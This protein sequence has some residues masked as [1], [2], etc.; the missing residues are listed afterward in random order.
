MSRPAWD[1][2]FMKITR[3][4]SERATCVKRQVGSIIVKD[5]RVLASGYN[6]A[7]KGFN[8]CTEATCLRKQRAIPSGERH[9]LCRGLHAEQNAIVQ[10]AW[11]GVKIEK[12][13]MYCNYQPCVICVKMMINAGIVRLIY[14]GGYPDE[15]ALQM[16]KE[17]KIKVVKYEGGEQ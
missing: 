5:N 11:H 6:G 9:E 17:S 2:Y 12:S 13:T 16:L 8:H 7:P 14:A 4:V 10:A 3:D 1:D 15:L